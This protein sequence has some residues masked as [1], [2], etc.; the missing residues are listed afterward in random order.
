ML[1]LR[2][3]F[4]RPEYVLRPQQ[5]AHRLLRC[6]GKKPETSIVKLPWG[7]EVEVR[8]GEN[9]GSEIYHYGIFD[10]IVPET[11]WRLLDKGEKAVEVGANIGQKCSAMAARVGPNGEVLAFEPHPEIFSELQ[12][13]SAVWPKSKLGNLKLENVA[14]GESRGMSVLT[15]PDEFETNRG[16][17]SLKT[18]GDARGG[19]KVK[20][21]KL[22]DFLSGVENIGLCKIDVE[23][24]ELS[25][26]RGGI[27]SLERR[28]IRDLIFEDFNP[29]SSGLRQF[30]SEYGFT[31]FELHEF[32]IKPQL[33][34]IGSDKKYG[35]KRFS[36]NYLATLE[37]DR[38]ILRFKLLG[39][40]C[41]L[42]I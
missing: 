8:V 28:K 12:R 15:L 40:R 16:S 33:V 5:V 7:A 10:K 6:W 20:V 34:L 21:C 24:H 23:G 32:W 38:A 11:I 26:L 30:L 1:S 4:S 13:N 31:I 14:L 42:K 3:F 36:H 37:P 22:D 19:F 25:V 29:E 9:I 41:L 27:E 18:E 39:W 35:Y 2:N 17:A